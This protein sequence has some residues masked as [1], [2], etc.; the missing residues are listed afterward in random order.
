MVKK[1]SKNLLFE[2]RRNKFRALISE[3]TTYPLATITYHGPSPDSATK[4]VVGILKSKDL[5]PV[6]RSWS[7]HDIGEDVEAAKEIALFIKEHDIARV[8]TSELVLSC[9]HEEG[10]DYPEGAFCQQCP[11]W[12]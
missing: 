8:L 3:N 12:N 10:T 6:I 2:N 11:D 1:G 7:G 5:A 9:P 4:I